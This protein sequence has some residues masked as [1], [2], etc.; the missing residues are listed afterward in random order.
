MRALGIT[1][2]RKGSKRLTGKNMRMICGKPLVEWTFIQL[3]NT[4]YIASNCFV[5][6]CEDMAK[7][8]ESYGFKVVFQ[9]EEEIEEAERKGR[10]G[11]SYAA[12]RGIVEM[13]KLEGPNPYDVVIPVLPTF[14]L[15][16]PNDF[17]DAIEVWLGR[18]ERPVVSAVNYKDMV[19]YEM[20]DGVLV[21]YVMDN[22]ARFW[23]AHGSVW[24]GTPEQYLAQ[25]FKPDGEPYLI[26]DD[27]ARLQF[28]PYRMDFWQRYDIDYQ[29]DLDI[30]EYFLEKHILKGKGASVY[31]DYKKFVA[32]EYGYE[33][34][35]NKYNEGVNQHL[36]P[37]EYR[38][39]HFNHL[40][41]YLETMKA[42]E[43]VV[44]WELTELKRDATGKI[45][46][47]VMKH[48][49]AGNGSD[50]L[51]EQNVLK[52]PK[53]AL[54]IGSGPSFDDAAPYLKDWEGASFCSSSQASTLLYY[55][56]EPSHVVVYDIR[57]PP[58]ELAWADRWEGRRTIMITHPGVYPATI[59][60]WQGRRIYFR[61]MD[62][63]NFYFVNVL[64]VAY[65]DVIK[66]HMFLFSC[67]VAAQ[68]S[69]AHAMGYS[70]LFFVGCDF[71]SAR[72]KKWSYDHEKKEW[73]CSP[74]PGDQ[75][76]HI[77]AQNGVSTNPIQVFYKR[78][79]LCVWRIDHSKCL[80]TSPQSIITEMPRVSF[81]SVVAYQGEDFDKF[82]LANEQIDDVTERYLARH[83]QFVMKFTSLEPNG[84]PSYR[85]LESNQRGN[86]ESDVKQ[87]LMRTWGDLKQRKEPL[88]LDIDSN[89][90]RFRQLKAWNEEEDR[91]SAGDK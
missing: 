16:K 8:A 57:T 46:R 71:A 42:P 88:D 85:I 17:D 91:A 86:W 29:E 59:D 33:Q 44:G 15:R 49:R 4:K 56:H 68:M 32:S 1:L 30:A 37:S 3:S 31:T 54:I 48:I 12:R 20:K 90:N 18:Q 69:L 58:S 45:N 50:A 89:M 60:A 13:K 35:A 52:E 79:V 67:S 38:N 40:P 21:S 6:D 47:N 83:N 73:V 9:P 19:M 61:S 84:K 26:T 34:H 36:L 80:M 28:T 43:D 25:S 10:S 23:E 7:L 66:T 64:P 11:G 39:S 63:S 78:S 76:N 22:T 77:T 55:G 51:A 24:V 70:P 87:Y 81:K 74:D 82:A 72:F 14:C 27:I 5:T 53:P 62:S 75:A 41:V 2:A 65:G